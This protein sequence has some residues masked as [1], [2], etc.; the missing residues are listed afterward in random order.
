MMNPSFVV[1]TDTSR[2]SIEVIHGFLSTSP[3]AKGVSKELVEKS[4]RHSLCFGVYDS[5]SGEQVG[6]ARVISDYTTFAYLSDV[7]VLESHRGH[8]L[9]KLL[10]HAIMKHPDLQGLRRWM[11]ITTNAHGLYKQFGF[12]APEHPEKVMEIFVPNLY[13]KET[14]LLRSAEVVK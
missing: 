7:F 11:L 9:S 12:D 3:W 4:I 2:L 1:S 6:F 5:V 13:Q 14:E 8:D 10:M